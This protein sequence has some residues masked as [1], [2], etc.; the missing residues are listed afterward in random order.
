MNRYTQFQG[1][2]SGGPGSTDKVQKVMTMFVCF[3]FHRGREWSGGRYRFSKTT[4][5]GPIGLQSE[6]SCKVI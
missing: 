4:K 6:T 1:V 2:E 5:S 3:V